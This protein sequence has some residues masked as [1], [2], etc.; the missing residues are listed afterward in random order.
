MIPRE[1]QA[2]ILMLNAIRLQLF[3][4][5]MHEPSDELRECLKTSAEL[6][7]TAMELSELKCEGPPSTGKASE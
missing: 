5:Q 7:D 3:A 4:S 6:A 2:L 1:T